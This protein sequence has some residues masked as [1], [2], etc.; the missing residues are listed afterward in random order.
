MNELTDDYHLNKRFITTNYQRN[1]NSDLGAKHLA[2]AILQNTRRI[3]LHIVRNT[4]DNKTM[5]SLIYMLQYNM[6]TLINHDCSFNSIGYEDRHYL[7]MILLTVIKFIMYD[8]YSN[9]IDCYKSLYW[10]NTLQIYVVINF[11]LK[12]LV[13]I[14]YPP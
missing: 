8:F 7:S 12:Y 2:D 4:I 1:F 9:H 14:F 5:E 13:F 10:V 3:T 11:L 6:P